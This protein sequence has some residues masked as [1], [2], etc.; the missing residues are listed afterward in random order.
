VVD[1]AG[2][3]VGIVT[4]GDLRRHMSAGDLFALTAGD[5]MTRGPKTTPRNLLAAEAL[6]R[7][8]E[9]KVTS[10]FVVEDGAPVGILRLHD[11]LR[12][13]AA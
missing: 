9:W 7:M 2:K 3:L 6:R 12:A 13:G 8:N 11:I 1:D 10:V 5:V 4:D